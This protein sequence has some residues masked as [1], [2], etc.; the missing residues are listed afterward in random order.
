MDRA[1][2]AEL[3]KKKA[4]SK[5]NAHKELLDSNASIK[6]A[7][8]SLGEKLNDT[9]FDDSKIVEQLVS[10]KESVTFTED[11]KRLESALA[12]YH[13]EPLKVENFSELIEKVGEI[14]NADVISAING[15]SLTLAAQTSSQEAKD[16]TPVRRVRKVGD[17]FIFDDAPMSVSVSGGG[18]GGGGSSVQ[19]SLIRTGDDG[20]AIAIVNPDGTPIAG[21]G[22]GGGDATAAKQDEQTAVLEEIRD[23]QLPDGHNVTVDNQPTEFPLPASQVTTLTPQTDALT[24]AEL[25]AT[26]LDVNLD[27]TN[28]T[29]RI[30][31]DSGNP[32]ITYI[33]NAAIGSSE[34][35]SVWQIK[36]LDSSTGLIKLWADGNDDF[37]NEWDNRESLSYS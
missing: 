31:E 32:D 26:P 17:R 2:L 18:G 23:G 1:K 21:G 30:E 34:G 19:A 35:D 29:T 7:V 20:Q 22:S 4:D 15:L 8:L 24:D 27:T 28:Y 37:D 33:G 25:R 16:Y 13:E 12:K 5:A 14:H 9:P 11:I 10:L 6:E 3:R 36:R